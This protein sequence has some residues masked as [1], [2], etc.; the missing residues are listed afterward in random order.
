M[1]KSPEIV[2]V[3]VLNFI[4]QGDPS[5]LKV[6][7]ISQIL[8]KGDTEDGTPPLHQVLVRVTDEEKSSR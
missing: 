1:S 3:A 7:V 6:D 8:S 2:S 5:T 4:F